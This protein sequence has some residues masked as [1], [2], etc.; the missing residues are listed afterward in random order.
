MFRLTLASVMIFLMVGLCAAATA[1]K[2]TPSDV[3]NE[4]I[5]AA[6]DIELIKKHL[7]RGRA[8]PAPTAKYIKIDVKPRHVW[9]K[10]YIILLKINL[11]RKLH[12]LPTNSVSSL[13]PVVELDPVLNYEQA[14]RIQT[15]LALLKFR[16]G[17][18]SD[19]APPAADGEKKATG[20]G[21][22]T[23]SDVFNLLH[24]M[25]LQLD[26]LI[27]ENS[28][29][30][31]SFAQT[32][33]ILDDI[34]SIILALNI[35]DETIPPAKKPSAVAA[36]SFEA[37]LKVLDE[38]HRLQRQTGIGIVDFHSLAE[39]E[40][41]GS[42]VLTITSMILAELQTLKAAVGLKDVLTSSAKVYTNKT[43]AEI[44][45]ILGWAYRRLQRIDTLK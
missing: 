43:Q 42:D 9:Q 12:G 40:I 28:E 26:S 41:T 1:D 27:G 5:K 24:N 38:I 7:T 20:P 30:N 22:K 18:T 2:T 25:S 17:I 10:T 16:L 36:D 13:E 11:L 19:A 33:R 15:E 39:G 31:H 4:L 34:N 37:A 45:Q 32:M 44:S 35:K 14:R 3:Y 8:A 6:R 29:L 23:P 21:R